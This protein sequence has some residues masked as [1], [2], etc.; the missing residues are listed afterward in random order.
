MKAFRH[1]VKS[2]NAMQKHA[3]LSSAE[4]QLYLANVGVAEGLGIVAVAHVFG[5]RALELARMRK[6]AIVQKRSLHTLE[7]V[8]HCTVSWSHWL[9]SMA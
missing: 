8:L 5:S 4:I 1:V 6:E 9:C 7:F 2:W 3:S